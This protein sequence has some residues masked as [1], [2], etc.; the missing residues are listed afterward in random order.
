MDTV[1]DTLEDAEELTTKEKR[2][3]APSRSTD[4]PRA[5]YCGGPKL[6]VYVHSCIAWPQ[7]WRCNQSKH[8]LFETDTVENTNS[9]RAALPTANEA[10]R[11]V[12]GQQARF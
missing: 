10:Q 2:I 6:Y 4:R 11:T 7:S 3:D 1:V 8:H 5:E 12:Q 9:A